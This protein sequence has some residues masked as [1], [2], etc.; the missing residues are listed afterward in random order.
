ML[1]LLLATMLQSGIVE[2]VIRVVGPAPAT[3][4]VGTA[5]VPSIQVQCGLVKRQATSEVLNPRAVR[6]DDP[7]DDTKDCEW[8][9]ENGLLLRAVPIDANAAYTV[10]IRP[11]YETGPG[12]LSQ[13]DNTFK[14]VGR[15]PSDPLENVRLVK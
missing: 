8:A 13:T 10:V 1:A 14:R 12:P 11:R 9:D 2:Y 4:I 7:S 3:T 15:N 5:T 6:W